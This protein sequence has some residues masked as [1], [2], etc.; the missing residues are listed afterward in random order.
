MCQ[1]AI[2]VMSCF[3]DLFVLSLPTGEFSFLLLLSIESSSFAK[4]NS[5]RDDATLQLELG[6]NNNDYRIKASS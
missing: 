4:D 6:T 3:I 1:L 5:K 2:G